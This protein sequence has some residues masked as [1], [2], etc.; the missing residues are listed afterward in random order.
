MDNFTLYYLTFDLSAGGRTATVPVSLA[1]PHI[2]EQS[3]VPIDHHVEKCHLASTGRLQTWTT[4]AHMQS[5]DGS[6]YNVVHWL[7]TWCINISKIEIQF[8]FTDISNFQP[9]QIKVTIQWGNA[10][11]ILDLCTI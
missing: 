6:E 2:A 4:S 5:V 10:P 3:H 1:I 9:L 8:S 7:H 11:S